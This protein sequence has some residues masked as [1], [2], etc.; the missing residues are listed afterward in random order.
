[1]ELMMRTK[2]EQET[3]Q[4]WAREEGKHRTWGHS[5]DI[6]PNRRVPCHTTS[7]KEGAGLS[8][9]HKGYG[10]RIGGLQCGASSGTH[11]G[12]GSLGIHGGSKDSDGHGESEVAGPAP[13]PPKKGKYFPWEVGALS[14][15]WGRFG[16][17]GTWGRC[18]GAGSGAGLQP[19]PH[20]PP[21][22]PGAHKGL[23]AGLRWPFS[24]CGSMN[25]LTNP[26]LHSITPT[27]TEVVNATHKQ[28]AILKKWLSESESVSKSIQIRNIL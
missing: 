20:I 2:R 21:A 15:T 6:T 14:G 25:M 28:V 8:G 10:E 11:D 13:P 22:S 18:W 9:G 16:G 7:N 1:M 24:I 23:W 27:Q 4:I 5:S 12:T 17:T 26:F 19:Y 3:D